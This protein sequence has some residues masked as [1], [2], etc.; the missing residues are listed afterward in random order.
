MVALATIEERQQ[1]RTDFL[2]ALYEL[3]DGNVSNWPTFGE[4]AELA[5]TPA[6]DV[7][8]IL[9][10]LSNERLCKVETTG[11]PAALV[12]I[13]SYGIR[14]AE[15]IITQRE[16][17]GEPRLSHLVVYTDQELLRVLEPLVVDILS[18][19]GSAGLDP[20]ARADVESDVQSAT[21]QLHAARPNRGVIRAALD[22][23]KANMGSAIAAGS[24]LIS[25]IDIIL[26]RLG[27]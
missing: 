21:D 14:Q 24:G 15:E 16:R 10:F 22:R 11:G 6:S 26:H 3:S 17:S 25:S 23:I 1:W 8:G 12:S 13:T 9:E 18:A 5:G 7:E 4:I 27:H 20:D 2:V 19:A